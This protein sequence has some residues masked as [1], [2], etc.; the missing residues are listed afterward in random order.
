MSSS[1]SSTTASTA[2]GTSSPHNLLTHHHHHHHISTHYNNGN[3]CLSQ[4][5]TKN[6]HLNSR[7]IDVE[8]EDVISSKRMKLSE[9]IEHIA[10]NNKNGSSKLNASNEP[11]LQVS[12]LQQSFLF[13]V[14]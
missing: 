11:T 12:I 14:G 10:N 1:P 13:L 4:S 7:S 8:N 9:S 3:D 6:K 2:S 5:P